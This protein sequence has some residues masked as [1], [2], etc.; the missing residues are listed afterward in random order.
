MSDS[1]HG[2]DS[3]TRALELAALLSPLNLLNAAR[4]AVP[5][6]DYALGAAGVA[7]AGALIVGFLGYG[8]T[9][10]IV[11]A[12]TLIAM[13]LLLVFAR[14]AAARTRAITLAGEVLLWAVISFFCAFLGFTVT[15][16]SFQWP[17][18]W[19]RFIGVIELSDADATSSNAGEA[20]VNQGEWTLYQ[21][22]KK[23]LFIQTVHLKRRVGTD[24]TEYNSQRHPM[25]EYKEVGRTND[26][27]TIYDK[28]RDT[29]IQLPLNG[30]LSRA[31]KGSPQI[32]EGLYNGKTRVIPEVESQSRITAKICLRL[33][34]WVISPASS[35]LSCQRRSAR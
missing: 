17:S 20:K 30:G 14:L 2:D 23:Y 22:P 9:G 3:A 16:F 19:A 18:P 7:A 15:A 5:A 10:V 21:N 11:F 35:A 25:Y 4:Q 1:G 8:R 31:A 13:V 28:T 6:V 26:E 29:Y 33:R 12:G 24:W 27:V 34:S 32:W